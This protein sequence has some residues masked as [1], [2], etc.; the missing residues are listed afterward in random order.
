[1]AMTPSTMLD[2]GT[3][4]PGFRLPA[5]NPSVAGAEV[6]RDDLDGQPVVVV[7]TCNHCPYAVHVEPRLIEQA[8]LW[9]ARGVAVVAISSND[10]AAYP[11]DGPEAMAERAERLAYPFPYLYDGTQSVARDFDAACTPDFYLFD[12][13]HR[14]VYRGRLDDGRPGTTPRTSDLGD[15]VGQLLDDGTV[16]VAQIPSMGCNIKW[17]D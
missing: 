10:V 7:F 4:M 17:R 11:Q 15:A 14:L 6:G 16:T 5:V 1:M 3:A 12:A 2:L 9:Q 8:R 13:G